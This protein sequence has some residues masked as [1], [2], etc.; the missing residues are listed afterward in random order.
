MVELRLRVAALARL[1]WRRPTSG[2]RAATGSCGPAALW[3]DAARNS[4]KESHREVVVSGIPGGDTVLSFGKYRNLS[5]E[6][7][8]RRDTAY[9][10]GVLRR[11]DGGDMD[12]EF[13]A[14]ADYLK[15]VRA[16]QEDSEDKEAS[17]LT[18]ESELSLSSAEVPAGAYAGSTYA[19]VLEDKEYCNELVEDM[20]HSGGAGSPFW[21]LVAYILYHRLQHGPT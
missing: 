15:E 20:M 6:E 11:A 18:V 13:L 9:C 5:Y 14:F 10:D 7:A 1:A 4:T 21:P 12:E 3:R 8:L 2:I 19:E 16:A 17:G